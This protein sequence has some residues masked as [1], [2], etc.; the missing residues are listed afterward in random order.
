MPGRIV[1]TARPLREDQQPLFVSVGSRRFLA[2]RLGAIV[3]RGRGRFHQ[4]R[5]LRVDDVG[6]DAGRSRGWMLHRPVTS[7]PEEERDASYALCARHRS[8]IFAVVSH[9]A[10][11]VRLHVV[12]LQETAFRATSVSADVGA[13]PLVTLPEP[14]ASQPREYV[15]RRRLPPRA[16]GADTALLHIDDAPDRAAAVSARDRRSPPDRPTG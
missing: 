7:L 16:R 12:V 13:A 3:R 10:G 5:R 4:R 14:L 15:W 9:T 1:A 6:F 8:S 2:T 11:R